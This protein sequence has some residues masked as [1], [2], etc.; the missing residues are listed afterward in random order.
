MKKVSCKMEIK[1]EVNLSPST[2]SDKQLTQPQQP[3]KQLQKPQ[4]S[5]AKLKYIP[6]QVNQ[7]CQNCEEILKQFQSYKASSERQFN[8]LLEILA[9]HK[10]LLDRIVSQ[11][12]EIN[13][14]M[15]IFPIKS[16]EKL[17]EFDNS[18]ATQADPYKR[19]IRTLLDG[20]T[21]SNLHQVFG[22]EII[23]NFN[24]DGSFGKQRLR[25]YGNVFAAMIDVISS[26]AE[27]PD[28]CLRAAFQRQKKKY[29]KQTSRSK[30]QNK[31]DGNNE[32][33][34]NEDKMILP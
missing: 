10:V 1:K 34:D 2:M 27:S 32:I 23:M 12:A 15:D 6:S 14:S 26:F 3:D 7:S 5:K 20:N 31:K 24:V 33:D 29:F 8:T 18:L 13:N 21:E 4:Q 11:N 9:E 28:K 19:Q 17:K 30:L 22:Q 25:D 16:V